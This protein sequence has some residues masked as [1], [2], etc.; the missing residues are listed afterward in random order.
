VGGDAGCLSTR[1]HALLLTAVLPLLLQS[2]SSHKSHLHGNN[3]H[4]MAVSHQAVS[5]LQVSHLQVSHQAVSHQ[6][7]SHQAVSHQ[8][9]PHLQVPSTLPG[10][11]VPHPQAAITLTTNRHDHLAVW[12]KGTRRYCATVPRKHLGRKATA[13]RALLTAAPKP[14]KGMTATSLE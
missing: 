14:A 7:V 3:S 13:R 10:L 9:V 4:A 11:G 6:A 2:R 12:C 5:H 1:A 8:A